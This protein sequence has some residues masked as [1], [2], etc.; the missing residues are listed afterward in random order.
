MQC[1]VFNIG[2]DACGACQ[3]CRAWLKLEEARGMEKM[4]A[5]ALASEAGAVG[6]KK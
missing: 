4:K 5:T 6:K 3:G 1:N 2:G